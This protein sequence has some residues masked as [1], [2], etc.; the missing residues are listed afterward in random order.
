[1]FKVQWCPDS[2]WYL[3]RQRSADQQSPTHG[4]KKLHQALV[5]KEGDGVD[6]EGPHA[7]QQQ[8]LEEDPDPLL[9]DAQPHAVQDPTV[10]PPAGPRHLQ[11]G[12]NHVHWS[13]KAPG[14]H[15]R[16]AAGHQDGKG[17]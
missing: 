16:H 4:E 11:P 2:I 1:M 8:P 10:L 6:G 15:A 17:A 3:S 5:A 12:L 13:G 9:S 14:D 7:V